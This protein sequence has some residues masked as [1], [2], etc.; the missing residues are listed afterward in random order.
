MQVQLV[1]L[2]LS[3]LVLQMLPY[4]CSLTFA[5]QNILCLAA[6]ASQQCSTCWLVNCS[7]HYNYNFNSTASSKTTCSFS[8]KLTF[9]SFIFISSIATTNIQSV[10]SC[11]S[12]GLFAYCTL[13]HYPLLS[14]SGVA[15]WFICSHRA[16]IH[17]MLCLFNSVSVASRLTDP[18]PV[19]A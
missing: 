9:C 8:P 1:Q 15:L 13:P 2:S 11:P 3:M 18:Q 17:S 19:W 10:L 14:L 12:C 6:L 16:L 4:C 7:H 5:W